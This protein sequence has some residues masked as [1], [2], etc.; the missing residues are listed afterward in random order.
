MTE[1]DPT[2]TP[3]PTRIGYL[4]ESVIPHEVRRNPDDARRARLLV[5]LVATAI[6]IA[7]FLVAF[8][9]LGV[10]E[11]RIALTILSGFAAALLT[12]VILRLARRVGPASFFGGLVMFTTITC[13]AA[14]DG[15]MVLS[16][17]VWSFSL[18]VLAVLM[19][20][21]W[22]V[23]LW[24]GLV[25]AQF[26]GLYMAQSLGWL[27]PSRPPDPNVDLTSMLA[28]LVFISC[29][30]ILASRAQARGDEERRLL[31]RRLAQ[32]RK[33]DSLG[34]FAGGI[35][36]DFN[37][38][39][40]VIS[41]HTELAM[42]SLID[43]G[44]V[45]ADLEAIGNAS[46]RGAALTRQILLFS[47]KGGVDKEVFELGAVVTGLRDLIR[48]ILPENIKMDF[49]SNGDRLYVHGVPSQIEQVVMNLISNAQQAMSA[50]GGR[51]TVEINEQRVGEGAEVPPGRYACIAVED[52]G[53]GI[54][55]EEQTHLFEPFY[56]LRGGKGTG[57][58][59][60][61]AY[62]IVA[63]GGGLIRVISLPQVGSR[64]I[65]LLPIVDAPAQP[66]PRPMGAIPVH[67]GSPATILLVED[68]ESVRNLAAKAL[69]LHG[70]TVISTPHGLA[71][72]EAWGR[73]GKSIDLLLTDVI[74]PGMSGPELARTLTAQ[75]GDLKVLFMSGYTDD[76]LKGA[77]LAP[78]AQFIRK[79]F[80]PTDLIAKI[81]GLLAPSGMLR[82]TNE[83]H[84][85][86]PTAPG[87]G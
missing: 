78:H 73:Y 16:I 32:T 19:R 49:R 85:D 27:I 47:R 41:G 64:F 62:G 54:P 50:N 77:D 56:S 37:N 72:L 9:L 33:M 84:V 43:G 5:W 22:R 28:F 1:Q 6:P 81:N 82:K 3:R 13:L 46:E 80:A 53:V 74:M 12:L 58:G 75:R 14:M 44:D 87:P 24:L 42:G 29:V 25:F 2:G 69:S 65:V 36:H 39:L 21:G 83:R 71:G 76:H 31:E 51:L 4:L 66:T 20:S 7:L 35:A 45:R 61:T 8:M 17:L 68:E 18:P 34:R 79:P 48:G 67:S 11:P 30:A 40:T 63:D 38:L 55:P 10:D 86:P 15:G 26:I 59:L 70:Y 52:N 23:Y 57:L 60:A